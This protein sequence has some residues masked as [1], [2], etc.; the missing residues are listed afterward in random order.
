MCCELTHLDKDG[1]LHMVDIT[2]KEETKRTAVAHA[3]IRMKEQ[4]LKAIS[5]GSIKKGNVMT[6]AKIAGIMAAKK[7]SELIPL[8]HNINL[9]EVEL[10]FNVDLE[11][12]SIHITSTVR[13]VGKTGAEM[14]ALTAVTVAALT[15]YDMCKAMDK[16]MVIEQI[17]L[18]EK[19]G[20]KSGE[21][22]REQ[23]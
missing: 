19:S 21:W 22:K 15:I 14:E 1:D 3:S 16:G 5:S 11:E 20:G 10:Q 13:C 23:T 12:N 7:T 6:T 17:Y 9:T 4:T 18:V 2:G 8:C